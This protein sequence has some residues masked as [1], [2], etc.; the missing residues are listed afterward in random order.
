MRLRTRATF[1]LYPLAAVVDRVHP[2]RDSMPPAFGV[3]QLGQAT[4]RH[5]ILGV[6]LGIAGARA[7]D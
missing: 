3:R 4:W 5:A 2:A 7:A 6:A 1:G